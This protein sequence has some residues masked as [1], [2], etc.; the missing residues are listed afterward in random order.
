MNPIANEYWN[1]L[2]I[3]K[4]YLLRSILICCA[5]SIGLFFVL[6]KKFKVSTTIAMQTQY[7][8]LPLVSTFLPETL[9]PQ[10]LRS[11]REALIR[12]ALNL[13]FL[14]EI[15][16]KYKLLKSDDFKTNGNYELSVLAKRFE[17]IPNGSSGFMVNFTAKDPRIAY[18]VLNEFLA[19]LQELMTNDRRLTLLNLHDAIQEQLEALSVGNTSENANALL[20]SR[21]D[22]VRRRV[23][24]IQREI[25]TLKSAYSE[26]HPRIAA[27]N[28]QLRGLAQ[29]DQGWNDA[30]AIPLRD[31]IF[32]GIRVDPSSKEL[33]DDLLKKY[34]FI[35]IV[36]YMD[37]QNK[38]H[39]LSYL[40]EP[41]IPRSATWPKLPILL[42]WGVA[43]GFLIG[44]V[45]IF[46][47]E[48]RR[49]GFETATST[50]AVTSSARPRTLSPVDGNV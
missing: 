32:S 5:I 1:T 19:H 17:I 3:N 21:P 2:K 14:A 44:A 6:P 50:F 4:N 35:D 25:E 39:Y 43:S 30:T 46:I 47:R 18:D 38:D 26:K 37:Q 29:F 49:M 13:N 36:L 24:K 31:D 42:V 20:V 10:E 45:G 9:D 15:S 27:L 48:R 12:R 8:Q 40:Q 33:F 16:R 23:E 7:F 22:L 11:K 34:R 28:G 41:I